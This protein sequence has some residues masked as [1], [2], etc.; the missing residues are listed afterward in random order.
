M[1]HAI[2]IGLPKGESATRF[3][4]IANQFKKSLAQPMQVE[5]A[6]GFDWYFTTN[7]M[8]DCGTAIGCRATTRNK[9]DDSVAFRKRLEKKGW[10][11]N[12]IASAVAAKAQAQVWSEFDDEHRYPDRSKEVEEW[13]GLLGALRHASKQPIAFM[14]VWYSGNKAK[15]KDAVHESWQM[16]SVDY[17]LKLQEDTPYIFSDRP[18]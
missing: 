15:V 10:S 17:L 16:L 1:C 18:H 14:L 8:C 2:L 4:V 9:S 13:I 5:P 12:K 7:K 11:A 6:H 3:D